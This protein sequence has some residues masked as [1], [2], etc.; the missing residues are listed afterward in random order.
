MAEG[1]KQAR[2]LASEAIKAEQINQA[3]G[4]AEATVKKANAKAEAIALVAKSLGQKV[5][6]QR[7]VLKSMEL[8]YD[9]LNVPVPRCF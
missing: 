9:I 5:S 1:K 7:H 4:E 2:I 6:C 3:G 8:E